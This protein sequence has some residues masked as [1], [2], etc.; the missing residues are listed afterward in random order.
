MPGPKFSSRILRRAALLLNYAKFRNTEVTMAKHKLTDH[1]YIKPT[2]FFFSMNLNHTDLKKKILNILIFN[3]LKFIKKKT[4]MNKH[5]KKSM[6][7][8]T[9]ILVHTHANIRK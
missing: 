4:F 3:F 6:F 8:E 2:C 1:Y 9:F 7:L 5:V